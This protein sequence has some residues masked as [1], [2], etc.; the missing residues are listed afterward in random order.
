M[1]KV[2]ETTSIPGLR[3]MEE[4]DIVKVTQLF[5]RYMKRF[6]MAPSF[7]ADEARHQFL[8]GSGTGESGNEGLRRREGQVTWSYVVEVRISL[9]SSYNTSSS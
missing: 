8:S 3:E 1:N 4:K 7:S 6:G 2:P 5:S 9:C